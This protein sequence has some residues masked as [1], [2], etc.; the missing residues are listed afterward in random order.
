MEHLQSYFKERERINEQ[1]LLNFVDACVKRAMTALDGDTEADA[2]ILCSELS[3]LD[4]FCTALAPFEAFSDASRVV[5]R[6][7]DY[8]RS[9]LKLLGSHIKDRASERAVAL[10]QAEPAPEPHGHG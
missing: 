8:A 3:R 1:N 2:S 6:A 4:G 10:S 7:S 9:Q 5:K